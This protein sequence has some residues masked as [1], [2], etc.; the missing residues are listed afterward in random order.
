[1]PTGEE[2]ATGAEGLAEPTAGSDQ[3]GAVLSEPTAATAATSRYQGE[4]VYVGSEPP[5]VSP[6]KATSGR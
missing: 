3:D 2:T 6:S 5:R 4:G 1:M